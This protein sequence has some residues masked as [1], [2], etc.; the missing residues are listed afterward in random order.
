GQLVTICFS[1]KYSEE[2]VRRMLTGEGGYVGYLGT[3]NAREVEVLADAGNEKA[4]KIQNALFYQV[5]KYIG[6]MAVVLDGKA[7]AILLTGGLAYSNKLENYMKSKVSF[8]APV[9]IYPGED[10]LKALAFNALR[11]AKGEVEPKDYL[12]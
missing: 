4:I 12:K 7:D 3:N 1:G 11:M 2:Q 6:E 9:F 10:E 8:I 5:A